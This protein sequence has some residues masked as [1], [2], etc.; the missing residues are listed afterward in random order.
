MKKE[1]EKEKEKE[2]RE[3]LWELRLT[4]WLGS[5]KMVSAS[6]TLSANYGTFPQT[7]VMQFWDVAANEALF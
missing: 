5:S 6:K 1:K 3:S 4:F 7:F 2:K